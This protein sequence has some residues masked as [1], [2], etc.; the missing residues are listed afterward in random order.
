MDNKN[1]NRGG[2]NRSICVILIFVKKSCSIEVTVVDRNI[3]QDSLTRIY[4]IALI[5]LE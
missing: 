4:I 5:V 1:F 2:M 3:S